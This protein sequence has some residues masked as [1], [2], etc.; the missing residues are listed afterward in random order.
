MNFRNFKHYL[1]LSLFA[2]ALT[3]NADINLAYYSSLSGLSG[4]RL[5]TATWQLISDLKTYSYGSGTYNTWWCFYLTDRDATNNTVIDRYS[6]VVST[7]GARGSSVTGMNIEH[8]FPKSWWGGSE[9][10]ASYK[11]LYNLM[12]CE[13]SINNTK[14]NYAMGTVSSGV[15]GNGYTKVG[16]GSNGFKV[17]EPADEWKGVFARG[18]MYM[19]TAYQDMTWSGAGLNSL[20]NG[21]YPTLLPWASTL[22]IDWARRHPVEPLEVKRNQTISDFQGN[23]NPYVDFPNLMEYVWGDSTHVAFDPLTSVKSSAF[24]GIPDEAPVALI[25]ADYKSGAQGCTVSNTVRPSNI[26]NIWKIDTAYGWKAT[27]FY[28][29]TNYASDASLLTPEIDLTDRRF[30]SLSFTHAL[31]YCTNPEKYLSVWVIESESGQQIPLNVAIWPNGTN[32]TFINSGLINLTP[33]CGKRIKIAFRYTS[34]TSTAGTWEIGS[35]L[36]TAQGHFSGVETI[37]MEL[38]PDEADNA[39]AAEYYSL[40][41]RRVN[42]EAYRGIVIRRQGTKVSKIRL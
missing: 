32:W 28:N 33:Y 22:Y 29:N 13:S 35:I 36:L 14:S 27:A 7:F 15:T 8:S 17:W 42:P 23:R 25:D 4:Q 2:M 38:Q 21:A 6:K 16:N 11:D 34:D 39:M 5:K 41:G 3:A 9:S 12:P 26:A 20:S 30:A 19:A 24:F 10:P 1:A 18:Y 37:P 40:D 31:N